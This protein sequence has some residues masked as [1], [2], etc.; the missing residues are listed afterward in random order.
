[1][2][3]DAS[4][5]QGHEDGFNNA[6]D[7]YKRQLNDKSYNFE[8]RIFDL[9]NTIK[10]QKKEIFKLRIENATITRSLPKSTK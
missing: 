2:S 8:E 6:S 10:N 5:K 3:D 7:I 4:Y 1:M 9:M